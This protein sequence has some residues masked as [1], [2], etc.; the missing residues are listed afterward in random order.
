[1]LLRLV[2]KIEWKSEQRLEEWYVGR[3][4]QTDSLIRA[5][6][7]SLIVHGSEED[8]AHKVTRL[9]ALFA[10]CG[11]REQLTQTC[12]EHL[13]HEKQNWRPF[14]RAAFVP[15][16]SPLLRVADILPLQSTAI[17]SN[18]HCLIG[19]VTGEEPPYYDYTRIND[20]G[21]EVLP[22]DW[23]GL[24]LD[25][26]EE[27]QAFNRRQLE[28]VA[29]LELAAAIKAGE[30]FVTGSLSYDRFWDRLPRETAD[31]AAMA[32]YAASHGWG[33][34]AEGF[35]RALKESLGREAAFLERAVSDEREGYLKCGK[36]GR[37]IVTRTSA[38]PIPD[39]AIELEKQLMKRMPERQVLE[40]IANTQQ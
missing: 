33:E 32:A 2:R 17:T 37:P 25:D 9:E 7:D 31:P 14:A 35:V 19:S 24:V 4:H 39:S 6:H 29:L 23:R 40:S 16:R 28:V 13:R 5:F 8:P 34:G 1:M 30:M 27:P 21:P 15:F 38:S 11:G 20:F 10:R 18:L 22:R 36:D 3:H 12:A 26:P